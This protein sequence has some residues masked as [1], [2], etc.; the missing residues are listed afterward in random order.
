MDQLA[1]KVAVITGGGSG[2]GRELAVQCAAAGMRLVLADVDETG[3]A[4]TMALLPAGAEVVTRRV[5]VSD[6][7]AV[8][9]LSDLTYK[10][11]GA[12]HLLFNNAGVFV[13]GPTWTT[14]AEDWNWVLGVNLMGVVHGV[15]SFVP[16]M[17]E[18]G[19]AGRII[20]TASL[21]GLTSVPGSSVYCA[22]KH[23]V[24]TL[25][26]CLHHELTAA[27]ANIGVS[28]LCPAFFKTGIA[29]SDRNRPQA[30]ASTNPDGEEYARR[31][32]AAI[33]AGRLSA[34]RIAEITMEAISVD[35]FYIIPHRGALAQ[36]EQRMRDIIEQRP[37]TNPYAGRD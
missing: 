25:S 3:L 37:P 14:T 12:T 19:E 2:L 34:T 4:E 6:A 21:A 36:T 23:A 11:F 24:V 22:S 31:L 30:L 26:E 18:G 17:L 28:V 35:R 15:R 29:E 8:E 13:S 9:A 20:N 33:E 27:R 7:A 32:K 10:S 1:G 5:D 16:R